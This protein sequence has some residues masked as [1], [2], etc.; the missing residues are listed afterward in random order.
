MQQ[1]LFVNENGWREI[2][3]FII[4]REGKTINLKGD[5]WH[6]PYSIRKSTIDFTDIE[7]LEIKWVE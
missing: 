2:P 6:L 1:D 5:V 7:P 3:D 4:S